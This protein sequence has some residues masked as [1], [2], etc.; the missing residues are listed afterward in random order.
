MSDFRN[1][2]FGTG[3]GQT[4]S[5]PNEVALGDGAD[6][7]NARSDEVV[8]VFQTTSSLKDMFER[9]EALPRPLSVEQRDTED[10]PERR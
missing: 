8:T 3:D 5:L 10:L 1:R 9:L 7:M 4:I 2:I 6:P